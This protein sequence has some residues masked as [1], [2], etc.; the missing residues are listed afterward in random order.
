[1]RHE[2]RQF[3]QIDL[4]AK[5]GGAFFDPGEGVAVHGAEAEPGFLIAEGKARKLRAGSLR[6]PAHAAD[7]PLMDVYAIGGEEETI[8]ID[9]C[10]GCGGFFLDAGEDAALLDLAAAA[11]APLLTTEGGARFALPPGDARTG[12]VDEARRTKGKSA[13][14]EMM[15]GI[16]D[17]LVEH[18]RRKR[19]VQRT[20]GGTGPFSPYD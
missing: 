10:A 2:A 20:G 16:F 9:Y 6:C 12:V 1:M 15:L 18:Q 14:K 4:C 5:C 8:E 3:A 19:I 13:F 11:E 17:G 7:A